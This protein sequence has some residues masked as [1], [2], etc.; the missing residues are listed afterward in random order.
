[1][2]AQAGL[3]E[4]P[5]SHPPAQD[6]FELPAYLKPSEDSSSPKRAVAAGHPSASTALAADSED[7]EDAY[8]RYQWR[9]LIWQTIEFNVAENGFRVSSDY[10]MRDLLA[11]K[12]FWHDFLASNRQWNMGRWSDGDDFLVD[13]I[14][15]PMQG[16]VS[17]YLEIQNSPSESRIEWGDP[18]Y[19]RS[20]F[21][22]FLWATVFSTHE[23]IAPAGE[24]GVGNDGG[25][26]YGNQCHYICTSKTFGPGTGDT[27]Y[28][29]NTGWTDFIVTPTVGM[30]WV[31]AEDVL[32]RKVSDRL[33]E[34]YTD[35]QWPKAIRGALNPSRSF[36]N[37]LRW[38][39]P[40]YRD[41]Q[42]SPVQ[43]PR[44]HWFASD[45]QI[46]ARALPRFQFAPYVSAF[47]IAAN[48]AQCFNCRRTVV[49]QGVETT[50][51]LRGWL[52]FDAA[53][54]HHADASPLPSDRAGGNMLVALFGLSASRSWHYYVAHA[55][56]RQ[57]FVR[58]DQAYLTSP[59]TF[60]VPVYPTNV[61]TTAIS[62][63]TPANP[64]PGVINATGTPLEPKLGD[65]NHFVWDANV[66][67][68]YKLTRN[69]AIRAGISED[70]VR[71]RTDKVDPPGL[72]APPYLSWLSK[73]NF[74]NRG[75]HSFQLGPVFSF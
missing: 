24:A 11:H 39:M 62:P 30:L 35:Q 8:G 12:P 73:Q 47:S 27:K 42:E 29:N 55:A 75:N 71:Y 44:V 66:S 22:G 28:T 4:A 16:A 37:L 49:G 53:F 14:G 54:T 67:V 65:I 21:K 6:A 41:F 58:F 63:P 34:A 50:L 19:V 38:R 13:E 15:H 36:A 61:G 5:Y 17:A 18:G 51:R 60:V 69:L 9:D 56:L 57:G 40:W 10:V 48:T 72:G 20:R 32:D 43:P 68:D 59:V 52:G 23:K 3:P 74:I 64:E 46:A 33:T 45:E 25:F 2:L 7:E 1:M 70:I 26:T 31:L